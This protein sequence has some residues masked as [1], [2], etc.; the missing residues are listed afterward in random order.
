MLELNSEKTT[1]HIS[2]NTTIFHVLELDIAVWRGR[3]FA[4]L[5]D[6]TVLD[7]LHQRAVSRIPEQR[8]A[9]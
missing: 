1:L 6:R 2:T 3:I 4:W 5:Q 7:L 8:D 9:G